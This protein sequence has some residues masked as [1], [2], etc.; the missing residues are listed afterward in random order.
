MSLFFG[1]ITFLIG[2]G[3]VFDNLFRY[4]SGFYGL[5]YLVI[6]IL[7]LAL[8]AIAGYAVFQAYQ[9]VGGKLSFGSPS[10]AAYQTGTTPEATSYQQGAAQVRNEYPA[11]EPPANQ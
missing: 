3:A 6:G 4:N 7:K 2:F 1:A 11:A 5:Q 9:K 8:I 10:W